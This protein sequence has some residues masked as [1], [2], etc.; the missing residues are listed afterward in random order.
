M[1]CLFMRC[2]FLWCLLWER[3]HIIRQLLDMCLGFSQVFR[4]AVAF[5]S[6]L[7]LL[8]LEFVSLLC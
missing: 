2:L 3:M 8:L 7:L 1:W 4:Y 5:G 6:R